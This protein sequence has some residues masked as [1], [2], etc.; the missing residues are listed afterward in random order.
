MVDNPAPSSHRRRSHRKRLR[1]FR[2]AKDAEVTIVK[3]T[4]ELNLEELQQ[5]PAEGTWQILQLENTRQQSCH[6]KDPQQT[7]H[8]SVDSVP[9][10]RIY[11]M[12]VTVSDG[13]RSDRY[14]FLETNQ[15]RC[16]TFL[17]PRSVA[18][19][20]PSRVR[21]ATGGGSCCGSTGCGIIMPTE[22]LRNRT[23]SWCDGRQ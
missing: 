12:E 2:A 19:T 7:R 11:R 10:G 23:T 16:R 8:H 13:S 15:R 21:H 9:Q 5:T 6:F 3:N 4:T 18:I 14:V 1:Q 17:L 22:L 20:E